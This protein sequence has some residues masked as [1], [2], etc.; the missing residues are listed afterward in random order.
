MKITNLILKNYNRLFLN[1][2]K[3]LELTPTRKINLIIGTNGSGKSSL[4][5]EMSPLPFDKNDFNSGYKEI[6]IECNNKKYVLI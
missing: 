1:N 3:T 6:H 2:I 4:I 5:K